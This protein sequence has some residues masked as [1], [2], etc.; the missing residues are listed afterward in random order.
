MAEL[1]APERLVQTSTALTASFTT[2]SEVLTELGLSKA[3]QRPTTFQAEARTGQ[4]LSELLT[5]L[6]TGLAP[7]TLLEPGG[8]DVPAPELAR[9]TQAETGPGEPVL[10]LGLGG[11]AG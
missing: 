9:G 4:G 5:T 10:G 11:V 3:L 7:E 6:T 8:R 1:C 2:E